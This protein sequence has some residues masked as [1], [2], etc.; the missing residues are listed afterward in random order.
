MK[1]FERVV[2]I[3][4]IFVFFT[5]ACVPT[6]IEPVTTPEAATDEPVPTQ[7]A[8]TAQPE[9]EDLL[10]VNLVW[11]QHQ[12]LYYKD[13][14]GVYTR[15]W[16]RV[17]ATKDYYDMAALV[18]DYPDVH[19]TINLTPVLL[20]QLE[21]F[22]NNGAKDLY[23]VF[24]EKPAADLT[25]EE[26][27]FILQRFFDANRD[28][29]V[30]RFPR[31]L[32]LLEKR[33]GADAASIEKALTEFTEQD[34]RDLQIW[35][36]LA[37][38]DPMFLEE[39]PLKRLVD[40]GENF[41]E[42]DKLILFDQV[43][44]VIQQ[45]LPLHKDMQDSGQIEL[46][47]T[48]YAHPIL[49]LIYNSDLAEVGNPQADLPTRFSWP[50]DAITHLQ[51]SVEIYETNFGQPPKG[52]WPGEGS[53]A[54]EIIPM[55]S[56]AG[57]NWMAT[58]EQVL[59]QSLG[60]GSFN[61]DSLETVQQADALYRPYYVSQGDKRVAIV[62]RDGN[63]SDKI[64][65]EYSQRDGNE[66]ADDLM[67]RLENIRQQLVKEGAQGPHL[68]SIILD[69]E[70][71]WEYY[72]NDGKAFLNAMYQRFSDSQTVRMVTPSEYLSMFPEQLDLEYLFPGAW[73]SPNYDTWIGE[74]EER[75]AWEYLGKVREHLS[76]YDLTK[77]RETTPE[78]LALAQDFM[79]LAE[80]SDWFWWYGSDQD[81][82][83]DEYFDI[84]FRAL[85]KGVYQSLGDP[86][87]AFL[88]VPVIPLRPAA[89]VKPFGQLSKIT[90][91]GVVS[92]QEWDNS[93]QYQD[94]D[95]NIISVGLDAEN[96]YVLVR[97]ADNA[98]IDKG[99]G[100]YIYSPK[101]KSQYPFA[102]DLSN[103]QETKF[104]GVSASNLFYWDGKEILAYLGSE[105]GWAV[106]PVVGTANKG[107]QGLE[108][109][110]PLLAI[111]ETLEAGDDL[112]LAAIVGET[113]QRIPVEGPVQL[114]LPDLGT[115][116][117]ILEIEDPQG[118]DHGPG[119]YVYPTDAVFLPGAFDIQ[120]FTVGYDDKNIVFTFVMGAPITNPWGST[121]NLS[122]QSFDVYVD[123]DPDQGSGSRLLLGGRNAA[124]EQ[125]SGWDV[126]IWAE[127]WYPDIFLADPVSGEAKSANV[128]FKIIVSP[129]KNT[130]SLRVPRAVFGDGDPLK[131]GYAAMVLSQDGFPS[132]GVLRVRDIQSQNT[133]WKFG[134]APDSTN[135]TRIID[136]VWPVD[137]T[138]TQED[139][140]SGFSPSKLPVAD[141]SA[142]DFAQLKMLKIE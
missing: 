98:A 91:D 129:D 3:F 112:R 111:G 9:E 39:Q 93:A 131:W 5:S 19:L 141:L 126:A 15:P 35:F 51:K 79:Y 66:A 55:V 70:N 81:S 83:Q 110:I 101:S 24:A 65:F 77:K 2:G 104:V 58:G 18:R 53:V 139:F 62:F 116:Q 37:W 97:P 10:Y 22:A 54:Q 74:A 123:V 13:A 86:V 115:E 59:A 80:G 96:L 20:R 90:V 72:P 49:P 36:N 23:W 48:P 132:T 113:Q 76:K 75:T 12:P 47:T 87:P 16:V 8:A 105:D 21:D 61:R 140:L 106:S 25:L 102:L 88:D 122:V 46:I 17:H 89:P 44:E 27:T 30:A 7:S 56:N 4:L 134:G 107:S 41:S 121:A 125:N 114:I 119:G 67:K 78:K 6:P 136:Y 64:G 138:D 50:N 95:G 118:D 68:V 109:Q 92:P 69:G 99:T 120:K 14:N 11:H 108:V 82:G 26:K 57:Y 34:F 40:K 100:I 130:V 127:G 1:Y 42:E 71:A 73:F 142:D 94:A 117:V 32:K 33:G 124:L 45:V 43:R 28:N 63:I 60:I 84:G 135:H 103:K 29:I 128:D 133:Q 31:Y 137:L 85:L 52:L 38:F